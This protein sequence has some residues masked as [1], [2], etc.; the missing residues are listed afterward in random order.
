M[1]RKLPPRGF[2]SRPLVLCRVARG[3][4]WRRLYRS[5]LPSPLGWGFGPS[6][7]SDSLTPARFG[8]IYLGNSVK[9]CFLEAILRDRGVGRIA[10]FP[11]ELTELEGWTCATLQIK[12]ALKLVDLRATVWSVWAFPPTRHAQANSI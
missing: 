5:H 6:R 11:I 7:F 9:V 12:E 1:P 2:E 3:K 8:V 4:I 10:A